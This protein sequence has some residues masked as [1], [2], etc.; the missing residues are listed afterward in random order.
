MSRARASFWV[1]V[2]ILGAELSFAEIPYRTRQDVI[3]YGTTGIG[4]PY[5]WGGG[6]SD[7]NDRGFGGADCSGFVSK[8]WALTRW[9]PYRV[10]YH[11]YSTYHYIQTPGDY[12]TQVDRSDLLYGD[13]IVY[14][15]NDNQNGHIYLFLSGDGWG[16]HEVYEARGSAYGIVHRWRTAYS[17]ADVTKGI[18][19]DRLIENIGVTEHIVETDDSAPYYV[20]SGMTGSSQYDSYA[21][22]CREGDCRYRWVTTDRNETC[23]YT[24]DLPEAGRYRVYVTCNENS[25]NVHGV[26]VSVNHVEGTDAFV[27]D[28]DNDLYHNTWLPM[29]DRSFQLDAGTSGSV[30]WDDFNATPTDGSRVFRGDATKFTLDNRVE[31][32]GQGGITGK[33]A[34]I[35]GALDWLRTHESEEPDVI[36]VTCDALIESGCI[37]LNLFD[38]L[39]VNGDADGNGIAVTVAVS[40]G[41]ASDWTRACAMYLDIPIQHHYELRD[42][43]LIPQYV[44]AGYQTQ[45]YAMVIDEQNPSGQACAM[46]LVVENVTIAGSLPGNVPTDPNVNSRSLATLFG[47]PDAGYGAS[48]LQRSS[49]WAGDDACRQ[50]VSVTGLTITHGATRGLTL[51]SACTNWDIDGG[52]VITHNALEGMT[53]DDPGDITFCVRDSAGSNPNE[54]M[55]NL[56]SAIAILADTS[57]TQVDLGH[58]IIH[59]NRAG[60]GAGVVSQNAVTHI[61]NSLIADNVSVGAGGAISADGGAL[62]I[63][64]CTIANNSADQ[65]A[66][67]VF[68]SGADLTITNS[69]LWGNRP[70]QLQ[71]SGIV[72][73]S[74]VENGWPG[75][76]NINTDP[77]FVDPDGPDDDPGT[78]QD[79]DYHVLFCSPCVN[80]GDPAFVPMPGDTDIDGQDRVQR[81]RVD[82]GADETPEMPILADC[83]DNG[84]PD[85]C[86]ILD[87]TSRDIDGDWVP[88]E[89]EY[90]YGDFDLDG[91]VD[92]ADFGHLQGC[93]S[94]PNVPQNDPGCT[95]AR[96]DGD[97]DVDWADLVVFRACMTGAGVPADPSCAE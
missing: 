78:V 55:G 90:A 34:T 75:D 3:E 28:Q 80:A 73:Y 19:R 89:C 6:N 94:G 22:G 97:K 69:I 33:F 37:E 63:V 49:S 58:C 47:S 44:S 74:D 5:V 15:Y 32:D 50:T 51:E 68:C 86:D 96:L 17:G 9:T 85:P 79:N 24:P 25:E 41:N 16:E 40:P 20:D 18:R 59:G 56:G 27:W 66:G 1:L 2:A 54:F 72:T 57:G 23:T 71:G 91:D 43:V 48:V 61:R 77:H 53:L 62:T 29:G 92:Q 36:N 31:V 82:I 11:G 39:T 7:P 46:S 76:G 42:L 14:R 88:D 45:A 60:Q 35:Q 81:G 93:L 12:W 84:V 26:G 83:N 64:N 8:S 87:G 67:G 30:V 21:P 10:N 95:S 4:S 13:A 52:L 38:D 70:A 65:Y